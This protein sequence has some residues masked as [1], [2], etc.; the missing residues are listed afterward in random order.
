MEGTNQSLMSND[1]GFCTL[2]RVPLGIRIAASKSKEQSQCA[3]LWLSVG[4][5]TTQQKPI[6]EL[7]KPHLIT[8][9]PVTER[10]CVCARH[11]AFCSLWHS[12]W[13]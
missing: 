7:A 10:Y 2:V 5:N 13:S 6:Y 1:V 9:K 12:C 8:H 3:R 11:F 4:L